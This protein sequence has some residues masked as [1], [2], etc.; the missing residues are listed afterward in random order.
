MNFIP[1][2]ETVLVG[3]KIVTSGLEKTFPRGLLIGE[4]AV[5]E[6]EAYQP[7]QQAVLTAAADLSKLSIVSVLTSN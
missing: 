6:N 2:N 4:V 1:R 7:F 5:A 3:D